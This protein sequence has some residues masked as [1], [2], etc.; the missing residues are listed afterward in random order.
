M[1]MG[2]LGPQLTV[3]NAQV[4]MGSSPRFLMDRSNGKTVKIDVQID[5]E[6]KFSFAICK[7]RG[8]KEAILSLESLQ[9]A[10]LI[11]QLDESQYNFRAGTTLEE[12]ESSENRA[13]L[14]VK[15]KDSVEW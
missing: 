6:E 7:W 10:P 3:L 15:W 2:E 8:P 13:L 11:D 4:G 1:I 5:P 9:V 14:V 12:I